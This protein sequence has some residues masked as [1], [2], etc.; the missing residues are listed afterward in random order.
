MLN[1]NEDG[2]KKLQKTLSRWLLFNLRLVINIGKPR[3]MLL[4]L[5]NMD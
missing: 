3:T 4:L 5:S 2:G 1:N